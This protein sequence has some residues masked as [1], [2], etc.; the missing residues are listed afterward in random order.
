MQS[1]QR[2]LACALC[3]VGENRAG[4]ADTAGTVLAVPLF[5]CLTISRRR[6]YSPGGG[7]SGTHVVAL[8]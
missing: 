1:V 2:I 3:F 7:G 6:L 8:N 4:A 5:G